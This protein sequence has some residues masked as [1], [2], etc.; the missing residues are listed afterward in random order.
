MSFKR[1]G[2][3]DITSKYIVTG[4]I[5]QKQ[6]QFQ[7]RNVS[8]L[9]KSHCI[10]YYF[11]TE[12]FAVCGHIMNIIDRDTVIRGCEIDFHDG[13]AFGVV[14]LNNNKFDC[15]IWT[16]HVNRFESSKSTNIF[17]GISNKLIDTHSNMNIFCSTSTY[18]YAG[19]SSYGISAKGQQYKMNEHEYERES[20][21]SFGEGDTITMILQRRDKILEFQKNYTIQM[22]VIENVVLP[23]DE[24]VNMVIVFSGF[25]CFKD[26]SVTLLNFRAFL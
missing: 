14:N 19:L 26:A 9:I 23:K 12:Y 17:I 4:W 8:E 24:E 5:R 10:L 11:I 25:W 7:L 22:A 3:V 1:L 2:Q 18:H 20:A 16:F 21:G 15:M 13:S 6:Q